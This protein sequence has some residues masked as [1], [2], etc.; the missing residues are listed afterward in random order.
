MGYLGRALGFSRINAGLSEVYE[1]R[2]R[3]RKYAEP[4]EEVEFDGN[5]FCFFIDTERRDV[6]ESKN[7]VGKLLATPIEEDGLSKVR[8]TKPYDDSFVPYDPILARSGEK[9]MAVLSD[10]AHGYDILKSIEEGSD[11]LSSVDAC[12]PSEVSVGDESVVKPRVALVFNSKGNGVM[13]LFDTKSKHFMKAVAHRHFMPYA[14]V[15]SGFHVPH[16]PILTRSI[17]S[18]LD[19]SEKISMVSNDPQELSDTMYNHLYDNVCGRYLNSVSCALWN[20]NEK[21]WEVVSTNRVKAKQ[22]PVK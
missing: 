18:V 21:K 13:S 17:P 14:S 12:L 3:K 16:G 1:V 10:G 15:Y 6:D 7:R 2:T 9:G 22:F 4:C 8:I 5:P 19:R 20:S 11:Y